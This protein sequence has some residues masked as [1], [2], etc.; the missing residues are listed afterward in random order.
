MNGFFTMVKANL[1]LLLRNKGYLV[2]LIFLPILSAGLLSVQ[3][4]S[5]VGMKDNSTYVVQNIAD[6]A[7]G[8]TS[9]ENTKLLVKIY[10]NSNTEISDYLAQQLA[11]S[12]VFRIFRYNKDVVDLQ[13]VKEES[14]NNA[15]KSTIGVIVY[16]PENFEADVLAGKTGDL[17]ILEVRN[18][19]RISLL[20]SDLN[21]DMS[22]IMNAAE[23]TG[24]D[25]A[26]LNMMLED[27]KKNKLDKHVES[28]EVGNSVALSNQQNRQS[29]RIGYSVAALTIGFLFCGIFIAD[30]IV[31]EKSN[32]VYERIFLS[33]A[34]I[35]NYV[36]AK[37]SMILL[38]V[39]IQT[40]VL[41]AVMPLLVNT[42]FGIPYSSYLFLVFGLGLCVSSLSVVIGMLANNTMNATYAVFAIW[43]VSN[44]MAG[45]YFPI[46]SAA[47]WWVE[48][49]M[50]IP[51]HWMILAS[52]MLMAE[53]TGVYT[54]YAL[55]VCGY[56]LLLMSCASVGVKLGKKNN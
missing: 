56:L 52:E 1:K 14:I 50:L 53:K 43:I 26:T 5:E 15:G 23:T 3:S 54:M 32:K 18:D 39:I 40:G 30:I 28:I 46:A 55:M 20:E 13:S 6:R 35:P 33:K 51:Q 47:K 22:F 45:L 42:D 49:S 11:G 21:T 31:K 7:K 12:G 2:L 19:G 27:Q 29:T 16:I 8:I 36:L 34:S 4:D 48:A 44:I 24:Y 17:S 25:S 41:A 9:I 38:T 37:M 10:D